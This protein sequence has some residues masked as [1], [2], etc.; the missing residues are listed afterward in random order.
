MFLG[1][2]QV[3]ETLQ[4]PCNLILPPLWSGRGE[5][6]DSIPISPLLTVFQPTSVS[7]GFVS[8]SEIRICFFFFFLSSKSIYNFPVAILGS[9]LGKIL[10]QGTFR[11]Y[12]LRQVLN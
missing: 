8:G 12:F 2:M 9:A 11:V 4:P 6:G 10:P 5:G 7:L 3:I 1:M